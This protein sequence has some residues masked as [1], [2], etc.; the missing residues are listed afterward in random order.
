MHRTVP[1]I[2]TLDQHLQAIEQSS[3]VCR[4]ARCPACGFGVLWR[5]GYYYRQ[6]DR[7][8]PPANSRNPV[9]ICRY[10]CADCRSTCSRLPLCIAPRRW[11]DWCIQHTALYCLA[12]GQSLRRAAHTAC[13]TRHTVRRWRDWLCRRGDDFM[14]F[15]RSRFPE[16]GRSIDAP[17][18]WRTAM[19]ELSLA[20]AMAGLDRDLIVP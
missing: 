13:L 5:H 19:A 3:D 16:W 12:Y 15:L 8:R 18:F 20:H 6:A 14:F 11:H 17:A 4:P 10:R 9:P 7:K 1:A 2:T